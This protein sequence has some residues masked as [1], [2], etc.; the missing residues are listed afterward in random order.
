MPYGKHPDE[1]L[2][3]RFHRKPFQ[4]Q[5]PEKAKV[6]IFG[7]D[8]NYNEAL[9]SHRFFETIKEYQQ[10]GVLFWERYGVHHPFL[11]DC[12]PFAKNTGGVQYHRNFAKLGL[13]TK[14]AKGISF[15]ELLD[16]PT[17]GSSEDEMFWS[18]FNPDH[19][20]WLD[21]IITQ[22]SKRVIFL[23]DSVIRRMRIVNKK[24]G[25]FTWIPSSDDHGLMGRIGNTEIHKIYHFSDN[26]IHKQ[27][28]EIKK[29]VQ[30][31]CPDVP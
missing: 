3:D 27:I 2:N 16:I 1:E 22:K 6:V 10:D 9:T 31:F 25:I 26:R 4:G 17:I 7:I 18:L 13:S 23:S 19:A 29:L 30:S 21:S 15:V 24:Y 14:Y 28:P 8:A 11:L 20:T 12:Y 5:H